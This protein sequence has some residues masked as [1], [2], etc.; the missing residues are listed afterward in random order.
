[1]TLHVMYSRDHMILIQQCM[2][3]VD[4][5]EIHVRRDTWFNNELETALK[6]FVCPS[7]CDYLLAWDPRFTELNTPARSGSQN[8]GLVPED[9]DA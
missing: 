5:S 4:D 6:P 9:C 8:A 1:M 7:C 2:Y 3:C